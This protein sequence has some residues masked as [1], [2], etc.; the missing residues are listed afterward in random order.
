MLEIKQSKQ[1]QP[2]ACF[3][4]LKVRAKIMAAI[5]TYFSIQNVLE[6]ETPLASHFGVTD[7]YLDNLYTSL[8]VKSSVE[9]SIEKDATQSD[10]TTL[11]LQTSPEFAMKRLLAAGSG[12]IYQICKA[13]RDDEIGRHHNPEFSMLEWY[14]VDF[15]HHQLINDV[16]DLVRFISKK[17]Q[18]PM[19]PIQKKSYKT[20][21]EEVLGINP[22]Q[23]ES[24][25]IDKLCHQHLPGLE[26]EHGDKIQALFSLVIEPTFDPAYLVIVFDFPADQAS[27]ARITQNTD[28]TPVASRFE[29]YCHQIELA[30][31]FFELKNAQEQLKRFEQDNH[32]RKALNKPIKAID[33]RLIEALKHGLPNCSGVALGVDRLIMALTKTNNI[34][35]TLSFDITNA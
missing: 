27:L 4:Q 16:V 8:S 2:S 30:N 22:H 31:G 34:T 15:D 9:P 32:R 6:V 10:H 14:R 3:E 19:P 25:T 12:S 24:A 17:A 20:C 13:F 26:L 18:L 5:R 11:Q 29:C 35:D 28:G 7:V 21:F 1:W 23:T 33:M